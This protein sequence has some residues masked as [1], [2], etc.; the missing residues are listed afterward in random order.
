[1]NARASDFTP[2]PDAIATVSSETISPGRA[3]QPLV[4]RIDGRLNAAS[5][6]LALAAIETADIIFA[7]DSV[8][9]IFAITSEPFIVYTNNVL[10]FSVCD[11]CIFC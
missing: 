4:T 6:L 8:P 5:L 7:I 10:S 11:P 9:A 1:M 3:G 2:R